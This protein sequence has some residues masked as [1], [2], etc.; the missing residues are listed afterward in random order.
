METNRWFIDDR[1]RGCEQ[2][3]SIDQLVDQLRADEEVARLVLRV[4][5]IKSV[6]LKDR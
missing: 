6:W 1:I 5:V 2:I 3:D 4:W